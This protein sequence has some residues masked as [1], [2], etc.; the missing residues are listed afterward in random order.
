MLSLS[1][2]EGFFS[3]EYPDNFYKHSVI[4]FISYDQE[5]SSFHEGFPD[6]HYA[7]IMGFWYH[8]QTQT[9]WPCRYILEKYMLKS[10]IGT[11]KYPYISFNFFTYKHSVIWVYRSSPFEV[12]M[13]NNQT[14]ISEQA[15]CQ[16][17]VLFTRADGP[18]LSPKAQFLRQQATTYNSFIRR[19]KLRGC[20]PK[21]PKIHGTSGHIRSV[22]LIK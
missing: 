18:N 4:G 2:V 9:H 5:P 20:Y 11:S 8:N 14:F 6:S 3:V 17:P 1:V 21:E 10:V 16:T 15:W 13:Y 7:S 19:A 22:F 12:Y